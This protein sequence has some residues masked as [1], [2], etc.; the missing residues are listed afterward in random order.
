MHLLHL[1]VQKASKHEYTIKANVLLKTQHCY[2]WN[3][4]WSK[5]SRKPTWALKGTGRKG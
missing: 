4:L 1:A 2:L 3:L 5:D